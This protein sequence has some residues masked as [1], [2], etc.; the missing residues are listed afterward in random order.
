MEAWEWYACHGSISPGGAWCDGME[1][2]DREDYL[3]RNFQTT[4]HK[5]SKGSPV[6][7]KVRVCN[8]H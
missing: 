6:G 2:G 3:T 1:E 8:Y 5:P 4:I 7:L